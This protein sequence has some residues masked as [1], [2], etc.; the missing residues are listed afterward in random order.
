[1]RKLAMCYLFVLVMVGVGLTGGCGKGQAQ[2]HLSG[3]SHSIAVA[4]VGRR[5]FVDAGDRANSNRLRLGLSASGREPDLVDLTGRTGLPTGRWA[6]VAASFDGDTAT[7]NVN[8]IKDGEKGCTGRL[9]TTE[10]VL[11]IGARGHETDEVETALFEGSIDELAV[12]RVA[13]DHE[14]VRAVMSGVLE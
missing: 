6:H 4:G 8:G 10:G 13:L 7:L 9:H 11:F 2:H 14:S 3:A 1:M 12:F 5:S